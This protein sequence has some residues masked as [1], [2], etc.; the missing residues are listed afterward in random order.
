MFVCKQTDISMRKGN[1]FRNFTCNSAK[2]RANLGFLCEMT[3][4]PQVHTARGIDWLGLID[5]HGASQTVSINRNSIHQLCEWG[6]PLR[7]CGFPQ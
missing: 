2:G 6:D 3:T 5:V 4:N 1:E 7:D